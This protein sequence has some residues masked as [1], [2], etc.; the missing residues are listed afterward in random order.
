M[1]VLIHAREH[2]PLQARREGGERQEK[3]PGPPGLMGAPEI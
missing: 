1:H 2:T 3:I